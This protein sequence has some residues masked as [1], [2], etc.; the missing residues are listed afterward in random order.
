MGGGGFRGQVG[1][2]GV[3]VVPTSW[4]FRGPVRAGAGLMAVRG[5][6]QVG[7]PPSWAEETPTPVQCRVQWGGYRGESLPPQT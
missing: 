4:Q 5:A 6:W 1:G 2:A 7:P 3:G